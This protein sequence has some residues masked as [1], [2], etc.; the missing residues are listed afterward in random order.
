MIFSKTTDF[1]L[2]REHRFVRDYL[3]MSGGLLVGATA[4]GFYLSHTPFIADP[5]PVASIGN[6]TNV[7]AHIYNVVRSVL[8]DG[9]TVRI[10]ADKSINPNG[11]TGAEGEVTGSLGA[12][13]RRVTIDPCTGETKR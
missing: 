5:M 6:R 7:D 13:L 12:E 9:Q 2:G 10:S 1:L 4:L 8:A 3:F 11:R